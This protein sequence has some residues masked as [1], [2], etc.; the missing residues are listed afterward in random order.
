MLGRVEQIAVTV[1]QV[2]IHSNNGGGGYGDRG[3]RAI[4]IQSAIAGR[5]CGSCAALGRRFALVHAK[6]EGVSALDGFGIGD[7]SKATVGTER[8]NRIDVGHMCR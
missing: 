1:N 8:A 7:V 4:A 6:I 2:D 5:C 3:I